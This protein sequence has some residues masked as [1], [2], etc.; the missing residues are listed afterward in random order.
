MTNMIESPFAR[1]V[2]ERF[3]SKIDENKLLVT[4]E[5]MRFAAQLGRLGL[6]EIMA[7]RVDDSGVSFGIYTAERYLSRAKLDFEN[8]INNY[9]QGSNYLAQLTWPT[10]EPQ[11]GGRITNIRQAV[12]NARVYRATAPEL[13]EKVYPDYLLV[14]NAYL[15]SKDSQPVFSSSRG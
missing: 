4:F 3:G 1:M 6:E 2:Y 11:F 5:D 14:A 9:S 13:A 7:G 8:S 15:N 10:H 12:A